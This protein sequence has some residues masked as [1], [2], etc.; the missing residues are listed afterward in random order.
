MASSTCTFLLIT[1][2]ISVTATAAPLD[3]ET[4][5]RLKMAYQI[6]REHNDESLVRQ[7]KSAAEAI[8]AGTDE[9]ARESLLRQAEA[10]VGIDPGGWSMAGQPLFHPSPG[11]LEKAEKASAQLDAALRAGSVEQVSSVITGWKTILGDQA[12]LPD[13]RRPGVHPRP[14]T[15][16]EVDATKLFVNA[17]K[18]EAR[19]VRQLTSGSPLP[20]QM[21]RVYSYLLEGIVTIRPFTLQHTP[22]DMAALDALAR[23]IAKI[24]VTLQQPEGH[25]PFPD[26]RGKNIRFGDMLNKQ[27][28]AGTIQVREGWVITADPD[29]GSQFDTGLCGTTLLRAG[30]V[31]NE[32]SWIMAGL[33]SA[34]WAI[35][36][37]CVTNF[38]YNAFSVSLLANAFT[39]SKDTKYLDAALSKFALGVAP[40]QTSTGR[41]IDPHNARTV[42]HNIILRSIGDLLAAIPVEETG[43][44]SKIKAIGLPAINS[45]VSEFEAMG[46]TVECLPELLSLQVH[47][48]DHSGLN[49]AIDQVAASIIEKSTDGTRVKMGAQPHQLAAVAARLRKD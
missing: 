45:L 36:Q 35:G 25:F 43:K 46:I 12:G 29:G 6:A 48:P 33:R 42:Y 37:R 16:N 20:D 22:D 11:L 26:L 49:A 38:N 40:G 32:P 2:L 28:A 7:V 9:G 24:L 14:L 1:G 10:A 44:I 5:G 27:L 30:K 15:I 34:D 17:L 47:F 21:V 41:W 18:S 4:E 31:Y 13:G 8:S 3:F 23:G 39:A 19:T